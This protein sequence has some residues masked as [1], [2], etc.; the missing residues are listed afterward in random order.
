MRDSCSSQYR[1]VEIVR[2]RSGRSVDEPAKGLRMSA[3]T[4]FRRKK[5]DKIDDG[6]SAPV[7][8]E[9]VARWVS[10]PAS[11]GSSSLPPASPSRM[12]LPYTY[13]RVSASSR[14]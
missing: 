13:A 2:V 8:I 12:T 4:I 11:N 9:L 7:Q 5:H 6:D 3:A 14:S 10:F 1:E